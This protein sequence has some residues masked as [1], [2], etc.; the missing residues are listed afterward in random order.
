LI[1][2]LS[3]PVCDSPI[4]HLPHPVRRGVGVSRVAPMSVRQRD[5][6]LAC[7]AGSQY[8]QVGLGGNITSRPMV[9]NQCDQL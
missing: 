6:L 7:E 5:P 8:N 9:K 4:E 1:H 3:W 2:Q